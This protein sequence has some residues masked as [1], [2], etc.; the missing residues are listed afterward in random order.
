M[1]PVL[2]RRGLLTLVVCIAAF[3]AGALVSGEIHMNKL[4]TYSEYQCEICHTVKEPVQGNAPLNVFGSDFRDNGSKWDKTLAEMDSDEDS[5]SNGF[6]LGDPEGDGTASISVERSNP[7]SHDSRPSS[8]TEESW[9]II[10]KLFAD[11]KKSSI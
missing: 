10:K 1:S 3:A 4:P 7:G 2:K 6:E 5:F 11:P 9:G 8:V